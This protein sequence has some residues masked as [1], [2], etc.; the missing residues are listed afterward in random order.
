[1]EPYNIQTPN[2]S[3]FET[4]I[5]GSNITISKEVIKRIISNLD[6]KDSKI[7]ILEVY[8]TDDGDVLDVRLDRKEFISSLELNLKTL[9]KFQEYEEC[10]KAVKA[11]NYL[12]QKKS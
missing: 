2:S 10:A 3:T 1:M 11:I 5:Q 4:L 8:F 12:K 6:T 7:H 9:E